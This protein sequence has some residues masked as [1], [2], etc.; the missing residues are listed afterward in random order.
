VLDGP[1]AGSLCFIPISVSFKTMGFEKG[2]RRGSVWDDVLAIDAI[3]KRTRFALNGRSERDFEFAFTQTLT[4]QSDKI[5]GKIIS[6]IDQ[7]TIVKSVY[8]FGKR[9]RPDLTINEDG[10]AIEIKY[11]SE[12]LDGI[13]L[14]LGQSM[15]YRLRYKFV[16]NIF[17]LDER[18]KETYSRASRGEERD[19]ED[20]FKDLSEEANVFSY[21]VPA[22]SA[23]PNFRSCIECNGLVN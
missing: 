17:I 23:A 5:K 19:L 4:A 22:F 10:I 15:L 13:K 14:A 8:C 3:I 18:H 21:I 20:I 9:H 7:D 11:L 1:K 12:S 16:F 6:Q 2:I